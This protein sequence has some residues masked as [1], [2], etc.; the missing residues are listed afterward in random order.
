FTSLWWKVSRTFEKWIDYYSNVGEITVK[1][2][3][4]PFSDQKNAYPFDEKIEQST[5]DTQFCA[6]MKAL[7][8]TKSQTFQTCKVT[9]PGSSYTVPNS[10]PPSQAV[11]IKATVTL[12]STAIT[13]TYTDS[14]LLE[15]LLKAQTEIGYKDLN[16]YLDTSDTSAKNLKVTVSGTV[17]PTLGPIAAAIQ[18]QP[19]AKQKKD[20]APAPYPYNEQTSK[21]TAEP[22]F[23]G[24]FIALLSKETMAPP[25]TCI[26]NKVKP[27][28]ANSA[29]AEI[30]GTLTLPSNSKNNALTSASLKNILFAAQKNL[31]FEQ[32]NMNINTKSPE[33]FTITVTGT[34]SATRVRFTIHATMAISLLISWIVSS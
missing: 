3:V 24:L 19:V 11:A 15:M 18:F 10:N 27:V 30:D 23:C 16:M 33:L 14:L 28:A 25:V 5:Y 20:A 29:A 22:D 1:L 34:N 31:G 13:N 32:L 26:V 8:Q 17:S 12:P 2:E 4:K 7:L 21:E 6:L 9:D